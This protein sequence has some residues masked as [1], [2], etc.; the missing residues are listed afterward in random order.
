MSLSADEVSD[1]LVEG[2]ARA[3]QLAHEVNQDNPLGSDNFPCAFGYLSAT[4][5]TACDL[6][7]G[8]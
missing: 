4:V 2:L 3:E 7:K 8:K 5:R 1:Y 6:L